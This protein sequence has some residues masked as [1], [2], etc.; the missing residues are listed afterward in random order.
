M[1]VAELIQ[2]LD[3]IEDKTRLVIIQKD[4]EGNGYSPI[5]CVEEDGYV[6]EE[7]WL[8]ERTLEALTPELESQGYSEEDV[9]EDAVP[10][11]FLIPV[12]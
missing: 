3:R 11:L 10:A 8:G 9:D 7:D 4:G 1:T 2:E 6:A 5:S 12:N